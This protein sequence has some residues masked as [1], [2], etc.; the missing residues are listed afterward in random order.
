MGDMKC[1]EA[2]CQRLE[3]VVYFDR[4]LPPFLSWSYF[5]DFLRNIV[6]EY[7]PVFVGT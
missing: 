1:E 7:N 4:N 6:R 5:P 3:R 2:R